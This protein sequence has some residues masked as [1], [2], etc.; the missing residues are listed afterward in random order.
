MVD[1][2]R[3][4]LKTIYDS[5]YFH[6]FTNGLKD[7]A[8]YLGFNWS[9]Q[10]LTGSRAA[11]LRLQWEI[12]PTEA[13]KQ[14]LIRYNMEDCTATQI[15]ANA[16]DGFQREPQEGT[17]STPNLVDID[18]LQVPYQRTYGPFAT[19]SPEFRRINKAAYWNYQRERI[20]VRSQPRIIS[21]KKSGAA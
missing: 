4:L 18:T 19:T 1:R 17:L 16:I 15:V 10:L 14:M 7:V 2:A 11:V 6:T 5:I 20:F 3:N 13:T 12:D 9:D 8:R 21:N